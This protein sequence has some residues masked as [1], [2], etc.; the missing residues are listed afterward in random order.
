MRINDLF[1]DDLAKSAAIVNEV[2]VSGQGYP[3]KFEDDGGW[4]NAFA[5]D[6]HDRQIMISFGKFGPGCYGIS[7]TVD[8]KMGVTHGGDQFKIYATVVDAVREFTRR[9]QPVLLVFG[10]DVEEK[11]SLY[12]KMV[13][14]L[15]RDPEFK[16]FRLASADEYPKYSNFGNFILVDKNKADQ[17][18]VN[19]SDEKGHQSGASRLRSLAAQDQRE[20]Q[21]YASF[22]KAKANGD[23]DRGARMYARFNGRPSEVNENF[24]D[25]K[26]PG[27]KGLAKRMGVDCGKSV[28]ELRNIAKKSSGER[29][30]M[31]HWCAN[32]KAGRHK[33]VDEDRGDEYL[34]SHATEAKRLIARAL[35]NPGRRQ[36]YFDYIRHIR[37]QYGTAHGIQVHRLAQEFLKK[38]HALE[39]ELLE[40]PDPGIDS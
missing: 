2:F 36:D 32:M 21:E 18:N 6:V 23:W 1:P 34:T 33:K 31:A 15:A 30:R 9:Y 29:Q 12:K 13:Q 8:N 40:S 16:N 24:H 11:Q 7:F 19:E 20:R 14:K 26:K 25:G 3:L 22:V 27:R 35:E 38:S 28:S 4:I 10:T 5:Q 17:L 39:P 37:E